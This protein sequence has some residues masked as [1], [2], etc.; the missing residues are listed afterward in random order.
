LTVAH[1]GG[2]PGALR[3]CKPGNDKLI[4]RMSSENTPW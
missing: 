3:P 2:A 4:D 1:S